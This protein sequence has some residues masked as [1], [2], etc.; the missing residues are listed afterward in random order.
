MAKKPVKV[1]I[2]EES[3]ERVLLTAYDDG[4]EERVPIVK[5]PKKKRATSRPYWYWDLATGRRKFF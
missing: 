4:T 5:T 2:I 3:E 1:E